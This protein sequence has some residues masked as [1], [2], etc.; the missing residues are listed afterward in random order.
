M[1]LCSLRPACLLLAM[2]SAVPAL[3]QQGPDNRRPWLN[4]STAVSDDPRRVPVSPAPRGPEGSLVIRGGRVFDGTGSAARL[5]TVVIE[6]NRIVAVLPPGVNQWPANARVTDAAGKTVMPG[7]IDLHTHLTYT[8]P[9]VS[10][11]QENEGES[12]TL[13]GME[14]LRFYTE[15]GI[16]SVRDVASVGNAPFRLKQWVAENRIPGPRVFA[17]GQLITGTGGHG[18]EELWQTGCHQQP[19]AAVREASGADDW[20]EAVREQF[21]RGADLIKLA[22]HYSRD[23]VAAA[24]DEA[25]TLGLKV[26]VDAETFYIQWAVEA[27]ADT[28]EHPLPRSDETIQLMA[29]KGTASVPTLVPY[30]YIFDLAGGYFG[31]TSRRFDFSKDSNFEMLRKLKRAGIRLGVG[32][33]L[34]SDW[35]RYL[36]HAY[37]TELKQFV[38]AG[39]SIEQALVAGTRT[40]AEILGMA[41][42][43]GTLEPGKLA[44]LIVVDGQPDRSLDDLR[45]VSLVIRDGHV[46]LENGAVVIAPHVPVPEPNPK[47][48]VPGRRW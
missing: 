10:Q 35:F 47:E 22:S 37:I 20:R 46:I 42:K 7:L 14:R 12:A 18:A 28:I 25:H 13:R 17:A 4:S 26:T 29:R 6:R 44:D 41:D 33:D 39:F 23:E 5:A 24:V 27:G 16:T 11:Q 34:V 32:T 2:L 15:S 38:A 30:I 43:L 31:S 21:K 19:H 9:G 40:S 36:P 1:T 48:T 3:A 45:R 8:E